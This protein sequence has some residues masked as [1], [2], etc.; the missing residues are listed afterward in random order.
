MSNQR[1]NNGI[2]KFETG[3]QVFSFAQDHDLECKYGA[4]HGFVKAPPDKRDKGDMTVPMGTLSIGVR[5]KITKWLLAII[6]GNI[7]LC[8]WV[9]MLMSGY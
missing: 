7:L 3:R 5:C 8:V 6:G 2:P 4:K 1:N 9:A